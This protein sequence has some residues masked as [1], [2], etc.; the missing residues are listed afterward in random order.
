MRSRQDRKAYIVEEA[1]FLSRRTRAAFELRGKKPGERAEAGQL[2]TR[3]CSEGL[4]AEDYGSNRL[5]IT[6]VGDLGLLI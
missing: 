3:P 2:L 1:D 5:E 6:E 4:T